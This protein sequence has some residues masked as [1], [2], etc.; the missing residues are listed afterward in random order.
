MACRSKAVKQ[1]FAGEGEMAF[2]YC[3]CGAHFLLGRFEIHWGAELF[4]QRVH[5]HWNLI[6]R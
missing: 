6:D 1:G 3:V 4:G 2:D 5:K